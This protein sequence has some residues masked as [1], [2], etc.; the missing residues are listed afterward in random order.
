[1]NTA[2][3]D[4]LS[5]SSK[6][7]LSPS[8]GSNSAPTTPRSIATS[9]GQA[10]LS[11][12]TPTASSKRPTTTHHAHN[13][14]ADITTATRNKGIDVDII[15][16]PSTNNES[17]KQPKLMA[18]LLQSMEEGGY[19]TERIHVP[20]QLWYQ[21]QVRLPALDAKI[22]SCEQLLGLLL[23][24]HTHTPHFGATSEQKDI[25][26]EA[27]HDLGR[28]EHT[29]DQI[30]QTFGKVTYDSSSAPQQQS[31]IP[32]QQSSLSLLAST[33]YQQTSTSQDHSNQQHLKS[34]TDPMTL[35]SNKLSK[36]VERMRI[37]AKPSEEQ[38]HAYISSLIR[39][40]SMASVLDEWRDRLM[41][42]SRTAPMNSAYIYDH[43]LQKTMMCTGT[44]HSVVCSFVMRDFAILLNKWLKRCREWTLD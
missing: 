40:F 36:S 19:I 1:M 33:T 43:L 28:L 11:P 39:L 3:T 32:P 30:K 25:T 41:E 34:I 12:T 2:E 10:F 21:N 13:F 23:R 14:G 37:E 44:L 27:L 5:S 7:L 18:R 24:M 6:V 9:I 16:D 29:L 17:N 22:S 8:G 35:W 42:V 26:N 4:Y 15:M 31:S 20:K 38:V